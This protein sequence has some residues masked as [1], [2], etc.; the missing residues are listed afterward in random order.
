MPELKLYDIVASGNRQ[1][2]V[3]T[4]ITLEW[5][6]ESKQIKPDP[7][8]GCDPASNHEYWLAAEIDSSDPHVAVSLEPDFPNTLHVS[9]SGDSEGG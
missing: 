5:D 6:G 9:R 4:G 7:D 3:D 1:S 8:C 2:R